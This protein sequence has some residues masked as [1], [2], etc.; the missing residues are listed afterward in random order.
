M[1]G[2]SWKTGIAGW[3]LIVGDIAQMIAQTVEK[4]GIPTNTSAW[5]T[6]GIALASGVGLIVAK[7]FDKSN[8]QQPRA[9]AVAVPDKPAA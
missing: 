3:L 7:D 4:E 9:E 2:G 5:I 8:A 6:F 1:P